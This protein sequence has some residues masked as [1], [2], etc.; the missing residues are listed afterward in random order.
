MGWQCMHNSQYS[1]TTPQKVAKTKFLTLVGF[2]AVTAGYIL[3]YELH[4]ILV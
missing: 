4:P 3:P 1:C 2:T